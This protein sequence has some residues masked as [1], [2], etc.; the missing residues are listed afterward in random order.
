VNAATDRTARPMHSTSTSAT[1]QTTMNVLNATSTALPGMTCWT[2]VAMKVAVLCVKA[3][4]MEVGRTGNLNVTS[5]GTMLKISMFAL[6]VRGISRRQAIS[7][8]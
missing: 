8:R 2:I 5:I 3:A 4:M 6:S 7:I 1:R